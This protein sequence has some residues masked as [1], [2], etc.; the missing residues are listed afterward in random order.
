MRKALGRGL[1]ALIPGAGKP[2]ARSA[3]DA[4]GGDARELPLA[5][6]SPNTRQ[7]RTTFDE[8]A[9]EELAAS[10]RAQGVIQPLLVRPRE[11][12]TYELVAGERRLRA[13]RARRVA[14]G[15]GRRARDVGRRE[16]RDRA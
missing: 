8:T 16:S 10:I 6:I 14:H 13:A 7:P 3:A 1:D 15:A 5:S 9:L 11:D 4:V 12:G 2:P